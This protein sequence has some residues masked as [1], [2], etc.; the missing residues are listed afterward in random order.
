M[1]TTPN[2][3]ATLVPS[4]VHNYAAFIKAHEKLL[5]IAAA[6]FLTFHFYSKAINAWEAFDKRRVNID[7]QKIDSQHQ[8]NATLAEQLS[9][10][11]I[12]VDTNAK[13]AAQQIAASHKQ[14]QQQQLLDLQ[15]PLPNLGQRW[16]TLLNLQP[17]D[18]TATPDNKLA[19]TE[20]ASHTT[21]NALETI[22]D[23]TLTLSKTKSELDGCNTVRSKQDE[24]IAGVNNELVLEKKGRTDDA[25]LAKAAQRKA[26][27]NGFKWGF[28][29]GAAA[30]AAI[31]IVFHF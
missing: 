6:S 11:K 30:V 29:A 22:P 28:G 16:I 31:R 21:V 3:I 26:W 14:T 18:I 13:L 15:L 5:I 20:S 4:W 19:V 27:K 1:S 12:T 24:T 10:L 23:L 2:P 8:E 17:G 7:Q 9:A 25:K